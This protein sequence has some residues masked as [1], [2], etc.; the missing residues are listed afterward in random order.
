MK[1]CYTFF[2]VVYFGAGKVVK[3][4]REKMEREDWRRFVVVKS[5]ID[6]EV[7]EG[8]RGP[9]W[10]DLLAFAD[11]C[12]ERGEWEAEVAA[13]W[14]AANGKGLRECY[15]SS[16]NYNWFPAGS[17]N[18]HDAWPYYNHVPLK[19]LPGNYLTGGRDWYALYLYLGRSLIVEGVTCDNISS[20]S[21][22]CPAAY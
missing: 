12:S 2:A 11:W 16:G 17:V 3:G 20:I 22:F 18:K 9:G 15:S 21:S 10:E 4:G 6:R 13:R 14:C 19:L 8:Q 5:S 7:A 1:R